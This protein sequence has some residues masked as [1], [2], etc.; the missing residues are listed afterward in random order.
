MTITTKE[1]ALKLHK[2]PETIRRWIKAGKLKARK[3][4]GTY[5][6]YL[7]EEEDLKNYLLKDFGKGV[8]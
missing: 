8:E 2:H 5:G 4:A 3:V 7:I 1:T 6:L